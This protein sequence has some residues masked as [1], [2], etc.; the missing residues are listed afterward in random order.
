M[1]RER[2]KGFRE[3]FRVWGL[4]TWKDALPIATQGNA[5]DKVSL[6][7]SLEV[8]VLDRIRTRQ[9]PGMRYE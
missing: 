7:T 4:T 8:I 9:N 5:E 1:R 6:E 2:K 3:N